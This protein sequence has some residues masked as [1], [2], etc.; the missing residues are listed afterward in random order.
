VIV[1]TDYDFHQLHDPPRVFAGCAAKPDVRPDEVRLYKTLV[2]DPRDSVPGIP[3][4]GPKT[5]EKC[6]REAFTR[7][8]MGGQVSV[9][10]PPRVRNWLDSPDN[11]RLLRAMWEVV[12]F[13]SVPDDE[14]R[15]E[16]GD[17]N[18]AVVEHVLRQLLI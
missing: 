17:P 3:G 13:I 8:V 5:W 14:I 18:P 7:L 9:E 6:D 1:S 15:V 2:G 11:R 16:R 4:F 10:A 12:G